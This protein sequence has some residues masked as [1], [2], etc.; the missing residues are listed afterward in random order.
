M[1]RIALE[2]RSLSTLGGGVR[3]YTMEVIRRLLSR[4][5]TSEYHV[6]YDARR[7]VGTFEGATEHVV[8]IRHPLLR[9]FWDQWQLPSALRRIAPDLVHY[10]KPAMATRAVAQS[11]ATMYDVMPLLFPDTQTFAQRT[12]WRQQLPRTARLCTHLLTISECSKRDIV[13]NLQVAPERITV[14]PP[15]VDPRFRPVPPAARAALR[16]QYRLPERFYLFLG[17][18]EPRKNIARLIR[19]FSRI[20]GAVPHDLVIAG[21]WGWRFGDVKT[22]AANP[23]IRSRVHFLSHVA[24]EDLPAL[25]SAADAFIFPS[26]YEG[27]GLPPLEAMACGTPVVTSNVSSLPE[28]V[29]P[30][31]ELVNPR[32]EEALARAMERLVMDRTVHD[33]LANE[34]V[35]W[36]RAFTWDRTAEQ[37]IAVYTRLLQ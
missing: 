16:G 36:S 3:T 30:H 1:S 35:V 13:E 14:T 34:G 15:G 25:Y 5:S 21:K 33:R 17:T 29:G 11:V 28:A 12:Y 20:A 4:K 23:R 27:F 2:A 37:T 8:P 10:F 31:A 6:V 9:F 26:L 18:I 24:A 7:Y 32:D 22:A 19:A